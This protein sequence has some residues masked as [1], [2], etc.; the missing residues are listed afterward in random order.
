[1]SYGEQLAALRDYVTGAQEPNLHA[2]AGHVRLD[3]SH[4]LLGNS[5]TRNFSLTGTILDLKVK[6]QQSVGTAPAFMKLSLYDKYGQLQHSNL[7]DNL[8]LSAY[9]PEDGWR[10][11]IDDVDPNRTI[12]NLT[13]VSQ[14]EKYTMSD[15]DYNKREGTYRKFKEQQTKNE[16]KEPQ[17]EEANPDH[18]KVG[19]R[20][21]VDSED[22]SLARR[23]TV[24]FVGKVDFG[25]GYW[26]GVKFDE[27]LGKNDGSIKGKRYFECPPKYGGFVKPNKVRVGD[28]PEEDFDDEL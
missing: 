17:E 12:A 6:L 20:C 2:P 3:V 28:Y 24:M 10:V 13:D 11:H 7:N 14:I 5:N 23:G 22:G 26:V 27:P 19:N 15:E 8:L 21:E 4:S 25:N 18:I 1:M 16:P 9:Y